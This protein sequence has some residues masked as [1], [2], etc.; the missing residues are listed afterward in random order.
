LARCTTKTTRN[1]YMLMTKPDKI[2]SQ[3]AA[4]AKVNILCRH[5]IALFLNNNVLTVLS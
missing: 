1:G 2:T 5:R 3:P 4:S